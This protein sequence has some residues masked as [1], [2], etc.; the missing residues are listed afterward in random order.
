M[1]AKNSLIE[2]DTYVNDLSPSL[3]GSDCR[4]SE[5][6]ILHP[7]IEFNTSPTMNDVLVLD[8][9][10]VRLNSSLMVVS[11]REKCCL[12]AWPDLTGAVS[13]SQAQAEL[14]ELPKSHACESSLACSFLHSGLCVH[15]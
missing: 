5:T 15:T 7:V 13:L 10:C 9:Y 14:A 3:W 8:R 2:W 11:S 6:S 12:S 1:L 4:C